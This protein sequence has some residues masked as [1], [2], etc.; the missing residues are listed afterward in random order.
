VI[1]KVVIY[2]PLVI[3][4]VDDGV[5]FAIIVVSLLIQEL[6]HANLRWDWGPLRYVVNSP[7]LHA[8]HH[9]V[10]MHGA[11]GQNFAVNLTLWD[12]L[13]GTIYWPRDGSAPA[14][15]GFGARSYLGPAQLLISNPRL[16]SFLSH[17][18]SCRNSR[19]RQL[20]GSR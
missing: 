3:L 16:S 5:V 12:F 20:G 8:W 15:L 14:E 6:I 19:V 2:V 17:K 13:F 4:G 10:E 7:R 11:S 18:K 1:Y 9:S